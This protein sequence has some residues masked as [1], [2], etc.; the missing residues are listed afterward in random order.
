MRP[1]T[2]LG[3]VG[4]IVNGVDLKPFRALAEKNVWPEYKK[5][6]PEMWNKIV[7]FK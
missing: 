4:M 6:Y 7:N 3:P 2:L 1:T 5:Q